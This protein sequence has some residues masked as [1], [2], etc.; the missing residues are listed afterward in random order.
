[1]SLCTTWMSSWFINWY[2]RSL[3]G[4]VSNACDNGDT[5]MTNNP[6]ALMSA[7]P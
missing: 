4:N 6:R 5:E 3:A 1:M 7:P 2:R